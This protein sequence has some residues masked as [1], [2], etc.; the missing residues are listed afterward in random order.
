[1]SATFDRKLNSVF[2]DPLNGT[3]DNIS[4]AGCLALA[5]LG[6]EAWNSWRNS[7]EVTTSTDN[8]WKNFANF[9]GVDFR[10]WVIDFA[11]FKFGDGANFESAK[12]GK[13]SSNFSRAKFGNDTIFSC[14]HFF[15]DAVFTGAE[16]GNDTFF[17]ARDFIKLLIFPVQVLGKM[18]VFKALCFVKTQT[19][20]VFNLENLQTL[21]GFCLK[22]PLILAVGNL[23]M[24]LVLTAPNFKNGPDLTLC[25]GPQ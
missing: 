4:P 15:S 19:L 17:L 10:E 9:C 7:Y 6:Y 16:F 23:I 13:N 12:F 14:T 20:M 11:N 1:M 18:L 2:E 5:K 25:L 8:E 3:R 21:K 24:G 22:E